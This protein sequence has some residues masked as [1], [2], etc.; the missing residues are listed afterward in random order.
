ML[1]AMD[2][3]YS[4][5]YPGFP[6]YGCGYVRAVGRERVNTADYDWDGMARQDRNICIFQ[7][8]LSGRGEIRLDG[9]MH[10]LEPGMAFF[11]PVPGGHRYYFPEGA[12]H[13]EFLYLILPLT[14]MPIDYMAKYG[15]IGVYDEDG[16]AV[17]LLRRIHSLAVNRQIR[18]G[19]QS[20]ALA[21]QFMMELFRS[22]TAPSA[23][24]SGLPE[25]VSRALR[26]M[27]RHYGR[28]GGL[29]DLAAVSGLSR[30]HFLR[31]FRSATGT[32]PVEHLNKLRMEKAAV[33][34]R[35]TDRTLDEIAAQVGF[36]N[37]NYFSKVFRHWVGTSPGRYRSGKDM[38][39]AGNL[40]IR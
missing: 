17:R 5:R 14:E 15:S 23:D 25:A 28:I 22:R 36:A 39:T 20:S 40:T 24:E 8:T 12:D 34:L 6:D 18:D 32:T 35:T 11:V 21:Y 31:L 29:D 7:I 30:Y 19:Y 16:E 9:E 1:D 38:D 33:L 27:E 2:D 3:S 4:F 10:K 26:Y 37:G 13:W